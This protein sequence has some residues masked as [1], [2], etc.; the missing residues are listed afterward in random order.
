MITSTKSKPDHVNM[1]AF[2][3]LIG[4][5][6]CVSLP[7]NR[8]YT[9]ES[10]QQPRVSIAKLS[11]LKPGNKRLDLCGVSRILVLIFLHKRRR[12]FYAARRS[13]ARASEPFLLFSS[14]FPSSTPLVR[15]AA[16][17]RQSSSHF[18]VFTRQATNQF[19]YFAIITNFCRNHP[20]RF[21]IFELNFSSPE[22]FPACRPN[23]DLDDYAAQVGP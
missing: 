18:L 13:E 4:L 20:C 21:T 10:G 8:K 7:V 19:G 15:C 11:S 16:S 14:S 6:Y 22:A 2:G 5:R 3:K 17:G 12:R 9:K 23:P 1:C